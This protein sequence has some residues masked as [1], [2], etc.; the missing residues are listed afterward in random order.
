MIYPQPASERFQ[1]IK[2]ATPS[3]YE[4]RALSFLR[5][6]GSILDITVASEQTAP[7]WAKDGK[8]LSLIHIS[9][10]TRPY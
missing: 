5:A 8:H 3:P 10:P 9:E 6:T 4:Y 2:R 1:M 7:T